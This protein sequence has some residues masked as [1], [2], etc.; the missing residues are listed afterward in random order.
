MVLEVLA[1]LI[2]QVLV[3]GTP[4]PSR[5]A[6]VSR[7]APAGIEGGVVEAPDAKPPKLKSPRG[8]GAQYAGLAVLAAGDVDAVTTESGRRRSPVGGRLLA[9]RLGDWVCE[10]EPCESWRTLSPRV[11]I[12]GADEELPGDG[13]TFVITLAPGPHTVDLR[14]DADGFVQSVSLLEDEVDRRNIQLLGA[15]GQTGR[16]PVNKTYQ[17]VE[18]T[19]VPL[20]SA[21]GRLFDT[22][23]RVFTVEYYQ[24]RFFFNGQTP[25]GPARVFLIVNAYYT[26]A[27]K[28]QRYVGL[29]ESTFV[30]ERGTVYEARDLDPDEGVAL[31][32]YEIP[33]DV[34]SGTFRVGGSI[35]RTASNGVQYTATLS[36]FTVELDLS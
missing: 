31:I 23:N 7:L 34:R 22:F 24:R 15:R 14:I 29:N 36:E 25:G 8:M 1:F 27:G 3:G 26:Y 11:R 21:D 12:D 4:G 10:V 30:D 35:D 13:D 32:G 9:F 6:E 5:Q 17:V 16:N 33:A 18:K 19:S 20:Q 28:T 2:A